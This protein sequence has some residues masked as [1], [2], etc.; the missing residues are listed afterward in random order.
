MTGEITP[1]CGVPVTGRRSCPSSITPA[2]SIARRS[3]RT[4]WS[5]TRSSTACIN[6]S[7]GI[8][9]KQE[10]MSVSTTHRRPRQHSSMSTCRASCAD[11]LGRNPELTGRKSA[12][13][14][15]S[16]TIFTAACTIR[17]RTGGIDSGLCSVVPGLG[18]ST[19]RAGSGRYR[20][21]LSSLASSPSSRA[22]P[23]S[24]TWLKVTLSMPGAPLFKRTATH[25]RHRTS[26]RLTLSYS[27]WNLRPGSALAARYSACCKARTGSPDTE[28]PFAAGLAETALTGPPPDN[29]A[30]RRSSGPS[31]HRRLCCPPGST[32][33][34]AASD[35]H[36]AS[37]PF[38]EVIGYRTP[39]S[40]D[41]IRRPPG[42]GG[43]PQFPPPPS[44]RSAPHTPGS[45]SRLR[46]Q[47]LRR[48][49]GLH[50]DFGGLGTPCPRP[51]TGP[52][53]TPQASRHATDRIVAPPCRAF[54]AG[55]RP[56]PFPGE[57]AS[58]LP[59]LLAATRTGLTPAGD[60]E[61]TNSKIHHGTTSRCHLRSAGRTKGQG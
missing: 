11:R 37:S 16:S 58:L 49:H 41:T 10:A 23:Y 60:D 24:S 28:D 36:P 47:A 35:A 8:A 55:L 59:G 9:E 34:T 51:R 2:R 18:I 40:G 57:A 27:A 46:F 33:T 19:R 45:P 12:S 5:Q 4:G 6:F 25:A 13:K 14:P 20:P 42:R 7:C 39:R 53:T 38:P 15:G 54:D 26:L 48:F 50:P 56:R 29:T 17:S 52:L 44:M 21:S 3:F 32:G 61:L 1:P 43:P 22:T 30:H 31:H